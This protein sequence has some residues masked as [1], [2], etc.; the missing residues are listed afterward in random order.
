MSEIEVTGCE[1]CGEGKYRAPGVDSVCLTCPEGYTGPT[2]AI[3]VKQC[4]FHYLGV[5]LFTNCYS[6]S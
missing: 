4:R 3:D 5:Y 2:D 1:E 6:R